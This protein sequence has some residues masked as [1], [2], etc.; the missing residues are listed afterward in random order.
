MLAFNA[1]D[2]SG[3]GGLAADI[4]ASACVGVHALPVMTWCL[5]ARYRAGF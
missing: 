4:T 2:P 5:G 3:A 1:S